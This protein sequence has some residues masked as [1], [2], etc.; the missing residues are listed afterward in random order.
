MQPAKLLPEVVC[1][2]KGRRPGQGISHFG[3]L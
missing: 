1:D 2:E 3:E